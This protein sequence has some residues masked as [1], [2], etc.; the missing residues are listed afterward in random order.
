MANELNENTPAA[1]NVETVTESPTLWSVTESLRGRRLMLTGATGFLGKV[2]ASMLLHD[3]PEIEQLYLLVRAR[4]DETAYE[5][6]LSELVHSPAFDPVRE[7][8]GDQY[9][10]FMEEKVT[11]LTGDLEREYLGIDRE[12]AQEVADQIDVCLLYTS[13][14]P[15]DKRQSRMPSSA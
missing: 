13:P 7:K 15:R 5:R 8:Q 9:L 14:S 11:V 3:Q 1:E 6:Y 10:A 2:Y 4:K 12:E